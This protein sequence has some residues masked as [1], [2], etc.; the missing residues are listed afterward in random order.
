MAAKKRRYGAVIAGLLFGVALGTAFDHFVLTPNIPGGNNEA[1]NKTVAELSNTKR[2][3]EINQAE[4]QSADAYVASVAETAVQGKLA[5]KAVVVIRTA[6][7]DKGD[8][9]N[10][11]WLLQK[12]GATKAGEVTLK[13]RFLSQ[14]GADA[15]KSLV[16]NT[17]PSGAQLS[18]DRL[19]SGT[20][21]GQAF[22]AGLMVPP[23]EGASDAD[24][25]ER[26]ALLDAFTEGGFIDADY[27]ATRAA[28]AA[29]IVTGDSEGVGS[30]SFAATNLAAFAEA[31]KGKSKGVVVAGRIHTAAPTG[32]IGQLRKSDRGKSVSTMD[33][34]NRA[35][36]RLGTVLAVQEQ[37]DGGKGA[38]GAAASADAPTPG[39]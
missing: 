30:E 18:S 2:Q 11:E 33:S 20:H 13:E 12:A 14:D 39:G 29:V 9:D 32:V 1:N 34:V 23:A 25:Q 22:A 10:V 37:L 3:S 26:S 24:E 7:A 5:D 17:L 15:V 38:Y 16:V 27:D 6:D 4:A 19:D 21:A 36:G 35:Y 28:D 8:V 31:L